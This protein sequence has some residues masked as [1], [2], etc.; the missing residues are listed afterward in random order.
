VFSLLLL[1]GGGLVWLNGNPG[2]RQTLSRETLAGAAIGAGLLLLLLALP[3]L[4]AL[5]SLAPLPP[6]G[7]V[8]V[9]LTTAVALLLADRLTSLQ[10]LP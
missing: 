9:L 3:R 2:S 4:Q 7:L 10:T 6:A 5:L 1:A 8:V